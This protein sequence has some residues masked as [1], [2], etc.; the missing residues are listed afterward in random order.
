MRALATALSALALL[1]APPV[2]GTAE[3]E[4]LPEGLRLAGWVESVRLGASDLE[5]PA[6]LDTGADVSSLSIVRLKEF[7]KSGKRWVRFAVRDPHANRRVVF[8]R[9]LVRRARIKRHSGTSDLRPVVDMKL[10]LGPLVK[11]AEVNLVDRSEFDYPMLIG[12]NFLEGELVVDVSQAN[13][14]E[15]DCESTDEDAD[16]DEEKDEE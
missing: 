7:R 2:G 3:P 12:R 4:R 16:D 10:C 1:P 9:K 5:V 15:L 6:K 13:V 11:E 14:W 8:E